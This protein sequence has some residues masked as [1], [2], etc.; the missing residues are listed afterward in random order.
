MAT[1]PNIVQQDPQLQRRRQLAEMMIQQGSSS[2]P[3]DHWT[4]GANR[5]LQSLIGSYNLKQADQ[6]QQQQNE[7]GQEVLGQALQELQGGPTRYQ[8]QDGTIMDYGPSVPSEGSG[9]SRL[10]QVLAQNP[11]TQEFGN[12]LQL[13]QLMQAQAAQQKQASDQASL[14]SQKDLAE[15]KA[16][17]SQKYPKP[18]TEMDKYMKML[19]AEKAQGDIAKREQELRQ[20]EEA[21]GAEQYNIQTAADLAQSLKAHP[22]FKNI[23][24][25]IQGSPLAMTVRQ[26]S[27]DAEAIRDQLGNILTL[28]ARG[29]LKGQGQITEGETSMLR[30]AQTMLSNPRISDDAAIA[31]VDRV[32][33]YLQG[34][35]A[36]TDGM[37]TESTGQK[38]GRRSGR[39]DLRKEIEMPTNQAEYDA[40]PSGAI[41]IDPDDGK[42]YRKP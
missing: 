17:L 36:Q 38:I 25:S 39:S 22:G 40:L 8:E 6:E 37:G 9:A 42:Q 12:Q 3:V 33:N 19:Q 31:E 16:Q 32:I 29:Q 26:S 34:K 23:Y 4:Q 28:A 27:I 1:L 5:I 14:Q 24:G 30:N 18:E 21:K 7:L 11:Y 15:Y 13:Q 20:A 41:F 35:G 10:A 2:A